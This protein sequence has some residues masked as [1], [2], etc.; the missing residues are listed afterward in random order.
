MSRWFP[1]TVWLCLGTQQATGPAALSTPLAT[2][3]AAPPGPVSPRRWEAAWAGL[4]QQLD[5]QR[6]PARARLGCVVAGE[7]VRY[8]LIPWSAEFAGS[9]A[10]AAFARHCFEE[11]YG[12]VAREWSVRH[13]QP[14]YGRAA[15]ACAIDTALVERVQAA[16][17]A[18]K[19]ALVALE[20]ALM[21]AFNLARREL[22]H[23]MFWFVLHEGQGAGSA[24]SL[25]LMAGGE[26]LHVRVL[27]SP[28]SDLGVALDR[29]WLQLG[30]DAPRCPV[31][32]AGDAAGSGAAP[33]PQELA[34]LRSAGWQ[35]AA[36]AAGS[37]RPPRPGVR[38]APVERVAT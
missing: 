2:D 26:P 34:S 11:T 17:A 19:L 29:E 20:P 8:R 24:L 35:V 12:A 10:R 7:F 30:I 37:A 15:L 38:P 18:R 14:G 5:A 3:P 27:Q 23:P 22:V 21:R 16:A 33:S 25:L 36:P 6:L 32:V 4:E 31:F 1:E 13:S 28:L 9:A